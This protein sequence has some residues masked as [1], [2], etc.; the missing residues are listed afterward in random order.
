MI[1]CVTIFHCLARARCIE[2]DNLSVCLFVCLFVCYA[3]I[4]LKNSSQQK[5][6][7]SYAESSF[8]CVGTYFYTE[9]VIADWMLCVKT[10][11]YLCQVV[12]K[13]NPVGSPS[14]YLPTAVYKPEMVC[15]HVVRWPRRFRR[16]SPLRQRTGNC[17]PVWFPMWFRASVSLIVI[18]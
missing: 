14:R 1:V 6:R 15:R 3:F 8:F 16:F 2:C 9:I 10:H 13:L 7:G 5:L 17:I 18:L 4:R 12:L 11:F